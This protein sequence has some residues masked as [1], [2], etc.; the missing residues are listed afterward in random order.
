MSDGMPSSRLHALASQIE[1]NLGL[2]QH[3]RTEAWGDLQSA[4]FLFQRRLDPEVAAVYHMDWTH[5]ELTQVPIHDESGHVLGHVPIYGGMT[6]GNFFR[7][8]QDELSVTHKF[9]LKCCRLLGGWEIT[10]GRPHYNMDAEC[11]SIHPDKSRVVLIPMV[12]GRSNAGRLE[13]VHTQ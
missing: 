7:M 10:I 3:I 13:R 8:I 2:T 5:D 6:V 4:N 1:R 12:D 11:S 9:E